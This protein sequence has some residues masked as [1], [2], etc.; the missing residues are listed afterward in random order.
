MNHNVNI[1]YLTPVRSFGVATHRLRTTHSMGFQTILSA[2][3]AW[4]VLVVAVT[5]VHCFSQQ[6][7]ISMV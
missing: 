2:V 5:T 6:Q 3:F 7:K 4:L 1:A